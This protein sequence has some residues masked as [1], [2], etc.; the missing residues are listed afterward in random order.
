MNGSVSGL[1]SGG[2]DSLIRQ[3]VR[4]EVVAVLREREQV[5]RLAVNQHPF[6]LSEQELQQAEKGLPIADAKALRLRVMAFRAQQKGMTA[7]AARLR[8][9]ADREE[10]G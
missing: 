9:Q 10:M 5:A 6:D 8:A 7:A 3:L 4:D 1:E 2:L